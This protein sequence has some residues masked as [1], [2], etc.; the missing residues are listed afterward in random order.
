MAMPDELKDEDDVIGSYRL[1]YHTDKA[2]FA[3]WSHREQPD[4][5][6]EGLAWTD[7]RITAG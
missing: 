6:D 3:N 5:W 2:T 4:W 7:R 1:Y